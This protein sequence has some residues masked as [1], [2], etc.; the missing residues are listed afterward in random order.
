LCDAGPLQRADHGGGIA[1]GEIEHAKRALDVLG[2][3]SVQDP[4]DLDVV[5]VVVFDQLLVDRPLP[6]E[7][8]QGR[9]VGSGRSQLVTVNVDHGLDLPPCGRNCSRLTSGWQVRRAKPRMSSWRKASTA[10]LVEQ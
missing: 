9:P 7:Q 4:V 5:E 3:N 1:A 8:L 6:P 2:Q 10:L